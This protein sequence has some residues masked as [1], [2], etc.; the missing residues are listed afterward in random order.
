MHNAAFR[1]LDIP[2]TYSA[3]DVPPADFTTRVNSLRSS[4][5]RGANV[6]IPHKTRAHEI[7]DSHDETA[8]RSGSVN[9][10]VRD[11]GQ[12][13][14]YD[15]D[16]PGLLE[17]LEARQGFHPNGSRCVVLG[18]GGAANAAVAALAAAGAEAITVLSRTPERAS[19]HRAI[20]RDASEVGVLGDPAA[21]PAEVDLIVHATPVGMSVSP[22]SEAYRD[23]VDTCD[24]WIPGSLPGTPL[25]LDLIYTPRQ[26]AFLA[27][28]SRRSERL[29]DGLE[30]LVR[31]A[32]LAFSLW[33]GKAAPLEGMRNAAIQALTA[34]R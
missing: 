32:G 26:S 24:A 1:A 3:I 33:T 14:G 21:W 2:M 25:F 29:E 7:A 4:P 28:A 10:F 17:A 30:M 16:G 5:W 9:T 31:Q 22:G 19:A 6:T 11:D 27:A 12:L 18:A 34:H 15:T 20:Q 8:R 23:A 13:L